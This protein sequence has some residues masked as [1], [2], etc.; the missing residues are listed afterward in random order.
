MN[1]I[2]MVWLGI[3]AVIGFVMIRNEKEN[4]R[5]GRRLTPFFSAAPRGGF[6]YPTG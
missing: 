2:T 6:F 4:E 3:M 1:T 5:K